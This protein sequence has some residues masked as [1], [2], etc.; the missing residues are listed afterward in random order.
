MASTKPPPGGSVTEVEFRVTDP[1]Y[2][3][4]ALPERTGARVDVQEILPR[5]ECR[6]AVFYSFVGVPPARAHD[7]IVAYE[8]LAARIISDTADGG[9]VEVV[10]DDPAEH[11]VVAL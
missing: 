1:G 8:H 2:P 3:L 10:V 4:V 5:G 11:F 9:I 7:A 6:Y